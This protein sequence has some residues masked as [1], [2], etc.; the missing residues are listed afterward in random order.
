M[1][2]LVQSVSQSN[3]GRIH[4]RVFKIMDDD[5]SRTLSLQELKKGLHDYG[6]DLSNEELMELFQQFDQ[7]QS[8]NIDFQEFLEMLR[9]GGA[10]V[11]EIYLFSFLKNIF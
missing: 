7:N 9:V 5:G 6:V 1:T 11:L 3:H 8:G 2:K 10:G 4:H